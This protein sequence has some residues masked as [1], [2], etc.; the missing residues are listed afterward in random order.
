MGVL[1]LVAQILRPPPHILRV[2]ANSALGVRDRCSAGMGRGARDL[3][4]LG[5][6]RGAEA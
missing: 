2:P 5:A 4:T 6:L 3:K 1:R